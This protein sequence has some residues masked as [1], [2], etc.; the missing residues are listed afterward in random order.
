MVYI[1]A[2]IMRYLLPRQ[3]DEVAPL[4][5]R[6]RLLRT[7]L[8]ACRNAL[9]LGDSV[10]AHRA[11]SVHGAERIIVCVGRNGERTGYHAI[12][13]AYAHVLVVEHRPLGGVFRKAS[14]RQA[15]AQAGSK[16]CM[17]CFLTSTGFPPG[18]AG[19]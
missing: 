4:S 9:F 1:L 3:G 2:R 13:T 11:L 12:P 18:A 19:G 10:E 5:E 6:D 16:Q 17:H 14:T 8:R 15:E 7:D